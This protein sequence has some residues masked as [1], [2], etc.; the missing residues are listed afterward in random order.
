MI[1]ILL[2]IQYIL[3][4]SCQLKQE[5]PNEINPSFQNK[6]LEIIPIKTIEWTKYHI[7]IITTKFL[8]INNSDSNLFIRGNRMPKKLNE[9]WSVLY[10]KMFDKDT[11]FYITLDYKY[12]FYLDS[13]WSIESPVLI[14]SSYESKILL[15]PKD[16]VELWT[17]LYADLHNLYK[18]APNEHKP[19]FM[20]PI[21]SIGFTLSYIKLPPTIKEIDS[22]ISNLERINYEYYK[23]LKLK[24]EISKVDSAYIIP[25]DDFHK[26]YLSLSYPVDFEN[27][28]FIMQK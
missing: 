12:K 24:F 20:V 13:M 19:N 4:S 23:E 5:K 1:R 27:E 7:S 21:D 2:I 11:N 16:T 10:K 3:I 8:A 17:I 14:P 22:M 28:I 6:G 18:R 15:L 9:D 26:Y 25:D